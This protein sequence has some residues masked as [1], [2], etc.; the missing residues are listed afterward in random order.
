MKLQNNEE[1]RAPSGAGVFEV[2]KGS[3]SDQDTG[4]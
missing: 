1:Y 4:I 2:R 3:S